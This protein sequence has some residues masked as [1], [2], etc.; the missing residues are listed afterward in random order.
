MDD[1]FFA[2][3]RE[4]VDADDRIALGLLLEQ[5]PAPLTVEELARELHWQTYRAEDAVK[6]LMS[7][8]L[9]NRQGTLA[10]AARSAVRCQALDVI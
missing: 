7:V 2:T 9:A 5:H 6:R 8:G 10:F 3:A 1:T 4:A